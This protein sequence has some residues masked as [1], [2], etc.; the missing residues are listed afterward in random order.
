MS[1]KPTD[2]FKVCYEVDD[3]YMGKSRHRYVTISAHDIEDD[4]DLDDCENIFDE[5]IQEDFERKISPYGKNKEE[6][7]KWALEILTSHKEINGNV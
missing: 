6:F 5:A 2:D 3:G 1:T 4:M 7:L